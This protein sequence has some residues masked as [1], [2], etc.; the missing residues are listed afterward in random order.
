MFR[1]SLDR[2]IKTSYVNLVSVVIIIVCLAYYYQT[3]LNISTGISRRSN[4]LVNLLYILSK[5]TIKLLFIYNN[6]FSGY[7]YMHKL[8]VIILNPFP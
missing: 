8:I 2:Y 4:R 3:S 6:I 5:S 7:T 1:E